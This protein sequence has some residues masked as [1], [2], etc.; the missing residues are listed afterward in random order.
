MSAGGSASLARNEGK[1][2]KWLP[3]KMCA[4]RAVEPHMEASV[5][6]DVAP[7]VGTKGEK[8]GAGAV[9]LS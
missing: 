4:D 5:E 9:G 7:V 8:I 6:F 1:G 2:K 3:S